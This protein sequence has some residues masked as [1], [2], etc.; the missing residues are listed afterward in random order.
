MAGSGEEEKLVS[1]LMTPNYEGAQD[2]FLS[3]LTGD[4]KNWFNQQPK[5]TRDE[6]IRGWAEMSVKMMPDAVVDMYRSDNS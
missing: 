2:E 5:A 1:D 3:M 4:R 6:I